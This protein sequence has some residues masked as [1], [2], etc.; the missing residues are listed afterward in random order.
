M[1]CEEMSAHLIDLL[2]G[3]LPPD[4]LAATRQHLQACPCCTALQMSFM[5]VRALVHRSM[6]TPLTAAERAQ[7]AERV[8][9]AISL[10]DP[11]FGARPDPM[12]RPR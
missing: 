10:E 1:N 3:E 6:E 11:G 8:L 2:Q 7:L 5:G 12:T 9:S 4:L